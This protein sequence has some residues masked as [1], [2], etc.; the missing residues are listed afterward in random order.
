M[1]TIV[2][3]P[4][5]LILLLYLSYIFIGAACFQ[6]LDESIANEPYFDVALFCFTT[7][8]T[9]GYGTICP[10]TKSAK[11]F[12]V[13]YSLFGMPLCVAI[14]S[15]FSKYLS[16]AYWMVCI[17]V[18][19]GSRIPH[20]DGTIPIKFII[21]L[22]FV[23]FI[24]G[25]LLYPQNQKNPNFTLQNLYFSVVSFS[26][27]GYGDEAP[28][29]LSWTSFASF[30]IYLMAG[31]VLS[32]IL[33]SAIHRKLS[34]L[35]KIGKKVTKAQDVV[36]WFGNKQIKVSKLLQVVAKEFDAKPAEIHQLLHGLDALLED[37]ATA[38]QTKSSSED[39]NHNSSTQCSSSS[40]KIY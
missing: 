17:C 6:F 4:Q 38:H 29:S 31:M 34:K 37:A 15:N 7:I 12:C 3:L 33:F 39:L 40:S 26:T 20:G 1:V 32:A 13:I 8:A 14:L 36:V 30:F 5:I 28:K 22:Y 11:I 21:F 16:K 35:N 19:K 2:F 27:T 25:S 10:K 24:F 23:L 18:G 9:I